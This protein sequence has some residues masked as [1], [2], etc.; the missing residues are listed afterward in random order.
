MEHFRSVKLLFFTALILCWTGHA[1]S[2]LDEEV[3]QCISS[4][5][6]EVEFT[7]R[8]RGVPGPEGPKGE[9]GNKGSIGPRGPQGDA[10]LQGM[11]G[12][13]GDIGLTGAQGEKG[14]EGSRGQ[15][16]EPG[17]TKLTTEEFHK[18]IE[19][20][21]DAI[22]IKGQYASFPAIS[23]KEIYDCNPNTPS[24]YYWISGTGHQPLRLYCEMNTTR[25]GNITGGW[26]RIAHLDV[27]EQQSCPSPLRTLTLSGLMLLVS[28]DIVSA[29]QTVLPH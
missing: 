10:G 6:G 9:Q 20:L 27:T 3:T 4:P 8:V 28:E 5:T 21:K 7:A 14:E 18:I 23:C 11:K 15:K 12:N 17:D 2:Q 22:C 25:C 1:L 13:H 16:G 29:I 24:G 26:M 19:T